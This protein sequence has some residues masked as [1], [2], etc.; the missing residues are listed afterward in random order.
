[1]LRKDLIDCRND[2]L[3]SIY[4]PVNRFELSYYRNQVIHLFVSE[5]T[6]HDVMIQLLYL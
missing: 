4:F 1:M 3:E 2:L 6:F 5:G